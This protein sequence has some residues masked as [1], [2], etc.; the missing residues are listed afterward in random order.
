MKNK[1]KN[2]KNTCCFTKTIVVSQVDGYNGNIECRMYFEMCPYPPYSPD[3]VLSSHNLYANLKKGKS[4][5]KL[6]YIEM[7]KALD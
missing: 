6:K 4:R 1:T 5:V 7:L 2:S 3:L